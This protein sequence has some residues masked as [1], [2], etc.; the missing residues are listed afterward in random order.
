MRIRL[1]FILFLFLQSDLIIEAQNTEMIGDTIELYV[2]GYKGGQIQWQFS[3]DSIN[4]KDIV[5][6]QSI[7]LTTIV[8][9]NKYYRAKITD[10]LCSYFSKVT[11]IKAFD[12]KVINENG[13][14]IFSK[15]SQ[16]II[17]IPDIQNYISFYSNRKY[18]QS[19]MD[20]N[21]M[22]NNS[23]F[24]TKAVLQLGDIT[25]GNSVPEWKVAKEVFSTLNGKIDYL[26]CTGNHDYGIDGKCENRNSYFSDYFNK[27]NLPKSIVTMYPNNYENYFYKTKLFDQDLIIFSLEFG[28][29]DR[30][31]N[32]ADSVAKANS[33][34]LCILMTHAYLFRDKQRFNFALYG[35]KQYLNPHQF[36]F[37]NTENVN[38]GEEIWQKL[39]K[40][41]SN[42]KFVINGHMT[43][44]YV[45]NL[46]SKN[47]KG[48][49]VLQMLFN[50]QDLPNGGD[51]WMQIL[52][53]KKN[54]NFGSIKT[55]SVNTKFWGTKGLE[56][57]DFVYK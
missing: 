50:T 48:E 20:W 49:N 31:V 30:V 32:W 34:T 57:Y 22:F 13:D 44:D 10:R 19:I 54:V 35:N 56:Q 1:C 53:F 37:S 11:Q 51:S 36:G 17:L 27:S 12:F 47:D 42:I 14:S 18:L 43:P 28:P 39:I 8:N 40:N 45:G 21:V 23:G 29:R 55:Y 41:N 25:N 26:L 46:I 2:A 9:E 5:G 16:F 24:K 52:E 4:W 7:S 3:T 33:N 38:D 15:T 6:S